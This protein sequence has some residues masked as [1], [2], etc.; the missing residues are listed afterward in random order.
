MRRHTYFIVLISMTCGSAIATEASDESACV[1]VEVNGVP[2]L[3]YECLNRQLATPPRSAKAPNDRALEPMSARTA[4]RPPNELG[5][6]NRSATS[7]RMG[8]NFGRSA[9][10]QR[11]PSPPVQSPLVPA[12]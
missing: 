6:F 11:P 12:R 1:T 5:V 7:I 9:T 4:Q 10:P 8:S 3:P 2:A